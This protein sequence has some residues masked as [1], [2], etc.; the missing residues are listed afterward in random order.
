MTM[1]WEFFFHWIFWWWDFLLSTAIFS[2]KKKKRGIS[3][4]MEELHLHTTSQ[5]QIHECV[6]MCL[7]KCVLCVLC[8]CVTH[9]CLCVHCFM[10]AVG[11]VVNHVI[12]VVCLTFV[13]VHLEYDCVICAHGVYVG[14]N[15]LTSLRW[16]RTQSCQFSTACQRSSCLTAFWY[17]T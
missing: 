6:C 7:H 17:L 4:Q 2:S 16:I 12:Y 5:E 3:W 13:C 14:V 11:L 9:G 10:R 15:M 1:S 8:V